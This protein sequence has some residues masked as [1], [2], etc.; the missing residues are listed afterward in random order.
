M[1][2]ETEIASYM[3]AIIEDITLGQVAASA[4]H[5]DA[6]LLDDLGLDSL[7]YGSTLLECERWLG[8]KVREDR[9]NWREIRTVRELSAFLFAQQGS[10]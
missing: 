10:R 6:R 9:V 7:D 4:I 1:R 8:I 3:R 5:E 2:T